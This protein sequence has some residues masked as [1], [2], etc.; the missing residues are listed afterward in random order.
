MTAPTP[1]GFTPSSAFGQQM[2]AQLGGGG[3]YGGAGLQTSYGG[4]MGGAMGYQQTGYPQQQQ[5]TGYPQQQQQMQQGWGG[6]Y[7]QQ[8]QPQQADWSAIA[9]F[10]PYSNLGSFEGQSGSGAGLFGGSG[11]QP[12]S[13]GPSAYS[14]AQNGYQPGNTSSAPAGQLHPREMVHKHK[15]ELEAWDPYA[16]KQLTNSFDALKSAWDVRTR[17]VEGRMR[18]LRNMPTYDYNAAQESQRLQG[19][20]ESSSL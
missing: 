8:Q 2:A 5:Q 11:T 4:G 9:Q 6:Q 20:R 7:Q 15:R 14:A 19:V 1:S 18:G 13:S 16:W 3:G 17:E 12:T 10:D